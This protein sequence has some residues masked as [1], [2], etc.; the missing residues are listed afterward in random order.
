MLENG[1][2][3]KG[4][5][6][7][8]E[9]DA[10]GEV[11]FN[12][13]MSGYQEIITDPSYAGQLVTMTYPEIGNTGINPED[14]ESRSLFLNGLV[15]NELNEPSNWRSKT[16]LSDFLKLEKIPA[17]AGI[18]TRAL[19]TIL[20]T[21]GTMKAF[22]YCSKELLSSEECLQK[23]KSWC[24]L[25]GQDYAAKVTCP[26]SYK[27]GDNKPCPGALQRRCRQLI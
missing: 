12:T 22:L 8:A 4:Y 10:L 2:V 17:I 19:T 16:S 7:G 1:V 5:S 13:G 18:D 20:R 15:V 25:D 23:A 27:W 11:V 6:F 21:K 3:F 9:I 26:K 14:N 24:G